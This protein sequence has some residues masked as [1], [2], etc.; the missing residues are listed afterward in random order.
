MCCW[1]HHHGRYHWDWPERRYRPRDEG[2]SLRGEYTRRL[3][4]ERDLLEQRLRRLE[5]ELEELRRQTRL[6][7]ERA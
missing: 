5:Q 4:E 7:Q 3:E 1:G 6:T 2:W